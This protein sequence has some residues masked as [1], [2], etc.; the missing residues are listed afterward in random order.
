[1]SAH[2]M[3]DTPLQVN[4]WCRKCTYPILYNGNYFCSNTKCDWAL[5]KHDLGK[6]YAV[7]L[8]EGKIRREHEV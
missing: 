6:E 2:N 1:M 8:E 5:S 4:E 3:D 7:L